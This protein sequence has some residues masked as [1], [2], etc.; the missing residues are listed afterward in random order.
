MGTVITIKG[1]RV[2]KDGKL[3]RRP[4]RLSVSAAIAKAKRPRQRY[5]RPGEVRP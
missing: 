1:Y 3:V 4:A 2:G 5:A